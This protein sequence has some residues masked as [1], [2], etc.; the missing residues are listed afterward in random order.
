VT[1]VVFD[2]EAFKAAY[3][4]FS[5][6]SDAQLN[7]AF[8]LAQNYVSNDDCSPVPYNPPTVNTRADVLNLLVA[9]IAQ[10]MFGVNGQPPSGLVGRV[11]NASEGTVSVGVEMPTT[12]QTAWWYQTT[13]GALAY[14]ALAPYRTARYRANPGRFAQGPYGRGLSGFDGLGSRGWR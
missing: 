7:L 14:A 12:P 3:T 10:I 9:H 6:V 1:V 8:E 2:P 11:S 13:W 4:A 5:T